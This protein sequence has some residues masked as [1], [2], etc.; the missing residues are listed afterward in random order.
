MDDFLGWRISTHTAKDYVESIT[1]ML[2]NEETFNNFRNIS[3]GYFSILEHLTKND[4]KVYG[5]YII[6]NNWEI[7]QYLNFFKENDTVGNPL[8]YNYEIFGEINPTTLRYI[9]FAAEIK[10]L[11]GDLNG[12]DLIEIGGGYGG[13]VK[14]LSCLYS[15]NSIKLFDLPQPLR[16]QEK[17]LEKFGIDV[18]TYTHQDEFEINE[19]SLVVSNYA[20]CECDR[21]TRDLYIEKIINIVKY[22]YMVVYDVD[23]ENELMVLEG[24]KNMSGDVLNDCKIFTLKR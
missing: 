18:E 8:T 7:L 4:G 14:V 16:L 23:V 19:N 1:S 10:K 3:S 13:L 24:E 11:F 22:V 12:V 20:W 17:Y 5:D 21:E 2:S 15:F 9:K 6:K